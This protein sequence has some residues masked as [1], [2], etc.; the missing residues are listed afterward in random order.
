MVVNILSGE[1][2]LVIY[3]Q[4]KIIQY[5]HPNYV[6]TFNDWIRMTKIFMDFYQLIP[7]SPT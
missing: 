4:K 2:V 5:G 1:D 6:E 7:L 3:I